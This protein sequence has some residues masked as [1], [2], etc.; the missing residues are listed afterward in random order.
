MIIFGKQELVDSNFQLLTNPLDDD[1]L[2]VRVPD[3]NYQT[4][5]GFNKVIKWI[6]EGMTKLMYSE[7]SSPLLTEVPDQGEETS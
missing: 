7:N 4:F 2:K 6:D 3:Y 5:I 1:R